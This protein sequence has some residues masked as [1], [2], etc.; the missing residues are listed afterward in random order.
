MKEINLEELKKIELNI[1]KDVVEFCDANQINYF[2]CGG[3]LLGAVR[4]NGF[5][6]WDDDI[7]IMIPRPDYKQ[8]IKIYNKNR[9]CSYYEAH[10]ID[11]D[12]NYWRTHCQVFDIR[13]MLFSVDA[14]RDKNK[15]NSIFVDIFPIDGMPKNIILQKLYFLFYLLLHAIHCGNIL[16][17][18][19][20]YH[21]GKGISIKNKIRSYIKY[22]FIFMFRPF[23]TKK[24][25]KFCDWYAQLYDYNESE[26]VALVAEYG[27]FGS[28]GIVTKKIYD[29]F[30]YL[31]FEGLKVKVPQ[32]YE[33]YLKTVFGNYMK[34][35]PENERTAKHWFK[36]Y[37][38]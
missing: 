32:D 14:L 38:K 7:D 10:A 18:Q 2:L 15:K 30:K 16:K 4:H 31:Y 26:Y 8:F 13:T 29:G 27:D 34:L 36:A 37:W 28:K 17:I 20:S 22:I 12:E 5:I 33:T 25:I 19:P 9:Q 23:N 11:N 3:T 24:I 21:Y 35:P 1:L 6:P